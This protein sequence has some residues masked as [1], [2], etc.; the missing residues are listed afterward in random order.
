MIDCYSPKTYLINDLLGDLS[1]LRDLAYLF[2]RVYA[3]LSRPNSKHDL[4]DGGLFLAEV[5][6]LTS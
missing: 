1:S 4:L 2:Y 3:L 5:M 6:E